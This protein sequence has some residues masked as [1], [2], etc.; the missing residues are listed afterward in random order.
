MVFLEACP[1]LHL[2]WE[3]SIFFKS[4]SELCFGLLLPSNLTLSALSYMELCGSKGQ[5]QTYFKIF[6]PHRL[7]FN[8]I[9]KS[10][11]P[12]ELSFIWTPGL[13]HIHLTVAWG[14]GVRGRSSIMFFAST[15]IH[16]LFIQ[17]NNPKSSW[18]FPLIPP[19]RSLPD[20]TR[21][22]SSITFHCFSPHQLL[23]SCGLGTTQKPN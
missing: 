22:V 8:H 15:P 5:N 1:I 14:G 7:E 19:C 6:L 4:L 11:L 18:T 17:A 3:S 21:V 10:I 13:G 9:T 12:W 20:S 16:T 23:W 2:Q